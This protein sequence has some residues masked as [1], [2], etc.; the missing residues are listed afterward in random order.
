MKIP[1]NGKGKKKAKTKKH[2]K[3]K[4]VPSIIAQSSSSQY[5]N[6]SEEE[7]NR[8]GMFDFSPIKQY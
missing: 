8:S 7:R 2:V 3:E 1:T 6:L 4:E 5:F